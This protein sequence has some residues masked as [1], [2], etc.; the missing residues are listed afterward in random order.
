MKTKH[1]FIPVLDVSEKLPFNISLCGVVKKDMLCQER[2]R[3]EL[4][5]FIKILEKKFGEK[6]VYI[7]MDVIGEKYYE[8][9]LFQ[10]GGFFEIMMESPLAMNAHFVGEARAKKFALALKK[11]LRQILPK[12]AVTKMFID[13]ITHDSESD[14]TLS[15]EKWT[16]IKGVRN[17]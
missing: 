3:V 16:K 17:L 2:G 8:R 4:N 11:A 13:N 15:V 9:F 10:K 7:G 5:K 1:F 12:T 14:A 6:L